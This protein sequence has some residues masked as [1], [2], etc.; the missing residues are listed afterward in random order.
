MVVN[1]SGKLVINGTLNVLSSGNVYV[2]NGTANRSDKIIYGDGMINHLGSLDSSSLKAGYNGNVMKS[3]EVGL[4]VGLLC[5]ESK[6]AADLKT[7]GNAIYRGLGENHGHYWYTHRVDYY[8]GSS[9]GAAVLIPSLTTYSVGGFPENANTVKY[10]HD[11]KLFTGLTSHADTWSDFADKYE[12]NDT[13]KTDQFVQAYYRE[14]NAKLLVWDKKGGTEGVTLAYRLND[15]IW[16]NATGYIEYDPATFDSSKLTVSDGCEVVEA[17]HVLYIVRKVV[18]KELPE[19]LTITLSYDGI[20]S[21]PFKVDFGTYKTLLESKDT[22]SA[23]TKAL[24]TAMKTYGDAA[25]IYFD[26]DLKATYNKDE[27]KVVPDE[28]TMTE[29]KDTAMSLTNGAESGVTGASL[30]TNSAKVYFDEALRMSVFFTPTGFDESKIVKIGLLASP[31]VLNDTGVLTAANHQTMYVLY[32]LT[33]PE[34]PSGS[35]NY[36][37]EDLKENVNNTVTSYNT[38]PAKNDSGRWELCFD[39]TNEMYNEVYELRPFVIVEDETGTHYVYGEQVH[40]SLAAYISR[41]YAKS[42][43]K[44]FKNLLMAT[45]DYIVAADAAF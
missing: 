10:E 4:A 12:Y 29:A 1:S 30:K 27:S 41:T 18:A 36:P 33:S 3:F 35:E 38:L 43:D 6:N 20:Q 21:A 19:T 40:Y 15:Y 22:T 37:D 17:D 5:G 16:V 26:K 28:I 7:F 32:S 11:A 34:I 8:E 14:C 25:K 42:T 2:T 13:K 31:G 23:A 39:L 24:L 9:T 45:W 44:A